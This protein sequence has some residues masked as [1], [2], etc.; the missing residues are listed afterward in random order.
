MRGRSPGSERGG[1]RARGI[2]LAD[3]PKGG[4]YEGE[5]LD[6]VTQGRDAL[7]RAER[8]SMSFDIRTGLIG[9]HRSRQLKAVNDVSFEIGAGETFGLVGESGCGKTTVGRTIL[10]LYRATGG[11]IVFDGTDITSM[12]D[13][14]FFPFRRRMQ[15]IFQDPYTSLNPRQTV[16]EIIGAPLVL[17]GLVSGRAERD[18]RVKELIHMVGLKDDHIN[19]YPHEF[20]GGQR[21]R[22][23]I[24]RSLALMP[25]FIVCDEPVSAL[26]VSIQ[27]QIINILEEFQERFG[28]A[29]L[30]ISHDLSVVR[31]IS[32]KVGVMYLGSLIEVAE[33]NELYD[34]MRHPYTRSLMSSAPVAD[35]AAA[36]NRTRIV[37]DGDVPSP[38]DPPSGCAFRTRCRGAADVCSEEAPAL[39][40]IGGGHMVACH[41]MP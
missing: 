36:R 9:R 7:L 12:T 30:F 23:G 5:G 1:R 8:L 29:Y 37:L 41:N 27:A 3:T 39:K 32:H 21:Q 15:M 17:H 4:A 2:L 31:H 13:R 40:D 14:E 26:D 11:R 16:G 35:P 6:T 38:L 33:V 24:A 34:N 22:I 20:S 25:E 28:F 10:K 19:R 18:D